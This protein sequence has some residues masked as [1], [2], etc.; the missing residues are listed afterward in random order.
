MD[1]ETRDAY[2]D[3]K[4]CL[5]GARDRERLHGPTIMIR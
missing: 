3:E 2:T 1:K 4:C 5:E